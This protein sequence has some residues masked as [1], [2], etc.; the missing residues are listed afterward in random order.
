MSRPKLIFPWRKNLFGQRVLG[1]LNGKTESMNYSRPLGD[2]TFGV[3]TRVNLAKLV[4]FGGARAERALRTP[5]FST[6]TLFFLPS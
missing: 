2:M 3:P 4:S 6:P 1:N 5:K